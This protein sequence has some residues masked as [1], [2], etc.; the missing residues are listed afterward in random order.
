MARREDLGKIHIRASRRKVIMKPDLFPQAGHHGRIGFL[1]KQHRV[2]HAG[3]E[4]MNRLLTGTSGDGIVQYQP[5]RISQ[6]NGHRFAIDLR[7]DHAA[8]CLEAQRPAAIRGRLNVPSK[9]PR[10]IAAHLSIAAVGI[11]KFPRPIRAVLGI[12]QINQSVRADPTLAMA[13]LSDLFATEGNLIFA[14]IHQH[15]VIS[16]AVHLGKGYL[17]GHMLPRSR[18]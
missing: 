3:V 5:L 1:H 16:R 13:Q 6:I 14:I 7:A 10:P 4:R 11:V 18:P 12:A 9:T 17:H 15:E 8:H 2:R